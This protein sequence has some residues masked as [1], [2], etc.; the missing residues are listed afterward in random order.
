MDSAHVIKDIRAG[1]ESESGWETVTPKLAAYCVQLLV[2]EPDFEGWEVGPEQVRKAVE[3]IRKSCP[4][5]V[6]TAER[7]AEK[8]Q[9][10]AKQ[11]Q[12]AA[13][14]AQR[15]VNEAQQNAEK[16]SKQTRAPVDLNE[17]AS[18]RLGYIFDINTY[19]KSLFLWEC[20][21][22]VV[23]LRAGL[24]INRCIQE[25]YFI[26]IN[27]QDTDKLNSLAPFLSRNPSLKYIAL[28]RCSLG[29][30]SINILS[31]ALLNRSEDTL[32]Q[33]ILIGN[34][35]LSK[36]RLGDVD[37]D[38]SHDST[39]LGVNWRESLRRYSATETEING[40]DFLDSASRSWAASACHIIA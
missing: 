7:K 16:H 38:G 9:E 34:H 14:E 24:Q 33:L 20:N 27:R 10:N 11:L 23:G 39:Q 31:N 2:E 6:A 17:V 8:L 18:R 37:L 1:P 19:V 13:D 4:G 3:H 36:K 25:L 28:E 12:K 30:V 35:D 29:P 40:R 15:I 32:E 22:D 21:L 5:Y 26:G